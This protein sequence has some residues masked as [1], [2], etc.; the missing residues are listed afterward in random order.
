[1]GNG[2]KRNF[3]S[4]DYNE[5][6]V[7]AVRHVFRRKSPLTIARLVTRLV[8]NPINLVLGARPRAYVLVESLKRVTPPLT[9]RNAAAA[10]IG[11]P[12]VPWVMAAGFHILPSSRLWSATAE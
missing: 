4:I 1:M 3:F 8:S 6:R 2:G 11:V 10:I 9:Y 5:L 7:S 12:R